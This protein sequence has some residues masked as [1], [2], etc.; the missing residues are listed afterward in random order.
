MARSIVWKNSI[1]LQM[2][3][4]L[5][6]VPGTVV[7]LGMHQWP[8][9][10]SLMLCRLVGVTR[11]EHHY[12]M[13]SVVG[14]GPCLWG[15]FWAEIRVQ[16]GN[17]PGTRAQVSLWRKPCMDTL[18]FAQGRGNPSFSVFPFPT[19]PFLLY[20]SCPPPPLF[21]FYITQIVAT[22]EYGLLP[23]FW[24]PESEEILRR[25]KPG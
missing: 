9:A 19:P 16:R 21:H 22:L 1:P 25:R 6:S 5:L 15:S 17:E 24:L 11:D 7:G 23:V 13:G 3:A 8:D 14:S 10:A 2:S 18:G 4:R 12:A 20:F